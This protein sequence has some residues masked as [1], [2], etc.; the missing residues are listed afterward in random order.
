MIT[1]RNSEKYINVN[2]PRLYC[3]EA[4][5]FAEHFNKTYTIYTYTPKVYI[6]GVLLLRGVCT[7]KKDAETVWWSFLFWRADF[8]FFPKFFRSLQAWPIL[9]FMSVKEEVNQDPRD[10]KLLISSSS[11]LL[12]LNFLHERPCCLFSLNLIPLKTAKK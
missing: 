3:D 10:F 12:N 1:W 11:F 5:I 2:K 9:M 7:I 8:Q 6:V 4:Y